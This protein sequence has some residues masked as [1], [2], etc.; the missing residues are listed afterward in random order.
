V[1]AEAT[2]ETHFDDWL[3]T[4]AADG[5]ALTPEQAAH[6]DSVGAK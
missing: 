5:L 2:L 4:A 6:T 1:Q 3:W